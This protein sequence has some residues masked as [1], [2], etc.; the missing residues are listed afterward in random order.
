MS[1]NAVGYELWPLDFLSILGPSSGF[2]DHRLWQCE[3]DIE[4]DGGASAIGIVDLALNTTQLH[5]GFEPRTAS[6]DSPS[7]VG[8][9]D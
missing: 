6:L 7:T 2:I 9:I 3:D 1:S 4:Q 8:L 5:S